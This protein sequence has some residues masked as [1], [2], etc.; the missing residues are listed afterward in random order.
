MT[1]FYLADSLPEE[2][3]ALKVEVM[4]EASD[5]LTTL[6]L[7]PGCK[8]NMQ[9]FDWSLFP[10]DSKAAL[11]ALRTSVVIV[12]T[13]HLDDLMKAVHSS[14]VDA[15]ITVKAETPDLVAESLQAAVESLSYR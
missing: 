12:L 8:L 10:L 9:L 6:A 3:S 4:G 11:T 7:A 14:G 1:R 2:R 15:C 13:N 5:W